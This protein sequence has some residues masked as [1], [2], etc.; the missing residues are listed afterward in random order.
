MNPYGDTRMVDIAIIFNLLDLEAADH[1]TLSSNGAEA[2]SQL[3][4]LLIYGNCATGKWLT[5]EPDFWALDG[6][7]E[8]LPVG[9]TVGFWSTALSDENGQFA[10]P[11]T[12][13]AQLSQTASSVGFTLR[14]DDLAGCWPSEIQ[15]DVYGGDTLLA[16]KTVENDSA[17]LFVDL[18]VT[19]Y[20][21]VVFSF[22]ET[23]T[24]FRRVKLF[25]LL[26]GAVEVF[27][28]HTIVSATLQE[29]AS[30]WCETLPTRELTFTFDNSDH[31]YN[32]F[33]PS[34]IYAYLQDGQEI[35][36]AISIDGESVDTG[37][38][39]YTS[40][41]AKDSALTA[42]I[43]ANDCIYWLDKDTYDAGES[44]TWTLETAIL[45]VL[46]DGISAEIAEE[47]KSRLVGKCIPLETTKREALRLLSQAGR[48]ACW[49]NRQG[50]V[51]VEPLEIGTSVDTLDADNMEAMDSASVLEKVDCIK[52]TVNDEF[53][54]TEEEHTSGE[55]T[56]TVSIS[57]PCVVEGQDVADWL[58]SVRQRRL[59]FDC[60]SR[61][62]PAVE[63]GDT[64][65]IYNAYDE[66]A[67]GTVET[68]ELKYDGGLTETTTALGGA[69][70]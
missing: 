70:T 15:V 53:A 5:L 46:G 36:T 35:Q 24:T 48:C 40:A 60:D 25:E 65:T 61:G 62:N 1:A 28:K 7:W 47:A 14:F 69:W 52:I 12:L 64:I 19:D 39:Y 50:V 31:K 2:V 38:F 3:T 4:D 58:L 57:N 67:L 56:N 30:A 45:T 33:N 22:L 23:P 16:T 37:T 66:S 27:D 20:D 42:E 41:T 21:K 49:C 59:Y 29:G 68:T 51:M 9:Q 32:F 63:V 8:P 10:S 6:T 13:T 44:G 17:W 43:T 18:P 34:G 55:G 11:P 26:F 54:D